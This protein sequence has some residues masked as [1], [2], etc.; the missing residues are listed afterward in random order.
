MNLLLW[1]T[2]PTKTEKIA[3]CFFF[4]YNFLLQNKFAEVTLTFHIYPPWPLHKR[5]V[6]KV[7]IKIRAL[8]SLMSLAEGNTS[9]ARDCALFLI[10]V[11]NISKK[12]KTF[13]NK[14]WVMLLATVDFEIVKMASCRPLK[15]NPHNYGYFC[16]KY[17]TYNLSVNIFLQRITKYW[18]IY[19]FS[20]LFK[21]HS[22]L[23]LINFSI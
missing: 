5:D 14:G 11:P 8:N 2:V 21:T 6:K 4:F 16:Q 3:C 1:A 17:N 7:S 9:S 22:W 15:D 20:N 23:S 18:L 19:V 13:Q 10:F 12:I